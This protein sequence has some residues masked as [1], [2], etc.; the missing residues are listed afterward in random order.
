MGPSCQESS[1]EFAVKVYP[2]FNSIQHWCGFIYQ[3]PYAVFSHIAGLA[4]A[5]KVSLRSSWESPCPGTPYLPSVSTVVYPQHFLLVIRSHN[6]TG[7]VFPKR[8]CIRRYA[9]A[10]D[11]NT[12]LLPIFESKFTKYWLYPRRRPFRQKLVVYQ[13]IWNTDNELVKLN[14]LNN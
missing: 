5:Y 13:Q 1:W 4:P 3:H 7:K 8:W 10:D 14:L 9:A 2:I 11:Y 12:V 6:C